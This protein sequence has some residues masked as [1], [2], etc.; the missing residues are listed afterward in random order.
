VLQSSHVQPRSTL[1]SRRSGISPRQCATSL[2][3][4]L[5]YRASFRIISRRSCARAGRG[6]G[7]DKGA[8]GHAVI[9]EGDHGEPKKRASKMEAKGS[10]IDF[11][12]TSPRNRH[13]H[14]E[15]TQREIGPLEALASS[16]SALT[17]DSDRRR[18][19]VL[20]LLDDERLFDE[21]FP[22]D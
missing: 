4:C 11:K 9:A 15:H 12:S 20:I 5:R 19:R 6:A 10:R 13:R 7:V 16:L 8:L 14:D 21:Q 22:H 18:I 3:I 1:A 2:A 17:D